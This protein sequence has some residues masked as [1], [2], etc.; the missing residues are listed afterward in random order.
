MQPSEAKGIL[1]HYTQYNLFLKTYI[2]Q[3]DLR[4]RC[5]KQEEPQI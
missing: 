1:S 3:Q 2:L 4:M 5:K